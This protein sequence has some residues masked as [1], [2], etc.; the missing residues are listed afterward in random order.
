MIFE[1]VTLFP[2]L[3]QSVLATSLLGKAVENGLIA[4]QFTDPRDF[5]SDKHRTVDD[6]PYGGGAGMVMRPD[7]LVSAI[8]KVEATRGHAHKILMTPSGRP[9]DQRTVVRLAGCERLL[10]VCARY[11]GFDE[12]VSEFVDEAISIGDYVLS[13]GELG[14]L[15][16]IDAVTRRLPGFMGNQAS[17]VEE[18]FEGGL[19]EYPQYTRPPEFRGRKVPE[20]LLSGNHEKIRKW[21]RTQA[22][23]R[24]RAR[25]P[26]L[27]SAHQLSAED[28]ELLGE[29]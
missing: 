9:L 5:T 1:V 14:A 15:V 16:I 21:R 19:L 8:E 7:P 23:E 28:E 26:D 2:E 22:L 29:D 6:T 24:T 3:F 20:V 25:R 18:S 12:R 4:V 10:I 27:W 11:E 17:P 13:G